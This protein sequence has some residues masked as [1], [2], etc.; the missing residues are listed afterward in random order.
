MK[1][2][3]H[4]ICHDIPYPA[5][6]GGVIDCF[7][8]IQTLHQKGVRVHLHCFQYGNR[9]PQAELE[10]HCASV[11]YYPR[12]KR[13]SATL[14]YIISSRKDK[15]LVA[16]LLKDDFPILMYGLHCS[17]PALHPQLATRKMA[18]RLLNVEWQYYKG[19]A[20]STRNLWR[21]AYYWL[22][23]KLLRRYEARIANKL[24]LLSISAEDAAYFKDVLGATQSHYLPAFIPYLD[25]KSPEG[26][27]SFC[28]YHGNLSVP[29]NE[30][31]ASWLLKYV[32]SNID[33]PFVIAGRNPSKKLE[34]LAHQH[35]NTCI[36]AN[37]SEKEM[38]DLI[39]K[40]QLTIL[41]A[42]NATGIKLKVLESLYNGRFCITNEN[43][44]KG[45]NDEGL[46]IIAED[47]DGMKQSI[48]N[49]FEKSFTAEHLQNRRHV[50]Q[51]EFDNQR[52]ADALI[53]Q[54]L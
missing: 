53:Q 54:L 20:Q 31:A 21:K 25:V 3:L 14:P 34:H 2:D 8:I 39:S 6:Y 32:F 26:R 45:F 12:K 43:A 13:L 17:W 29:E 37:P 38:S 24:P 19:L 41:P 18:L 50:L 15:A 4:L 49:W 10:R 48:T 47:T 5:N 40:A 28:L 11:H 46:L 9:S 35:L 51:H 30:M 27:G 33:I 22:E 16:N 44:R 36:A 42:F 52:N 1:N 23:S 7:C